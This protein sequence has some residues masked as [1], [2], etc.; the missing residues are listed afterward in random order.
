[1]LICESTMDLKHF[2]LLALVSLVRSGDP[3]LQELK[4]CFTVE[5]VISFMQLFVDQPNLSDEH[6]N[7]FCSSLGT[8]RACLKEK[9]AG[10]CA[11]KRYKRLMDGLIYLYPLECSIGRENFSA[12][13]ECVDGSSV[14]IAC[15]PEGS[16]L[17]LMDVDPP[18]Y[19]GTMTERLNCITAAIETDCGGRPAADSMRQYYLTILWLKYG[20][21]MRCEEFSEVFGEGEVKDEV[22]LPAPSTPSADALSS[23]R[24]EN[25]NEDEA[26]VPV[27]STSSAG[28]SSLVTSKNRSEVNKAVSVHPTSS[29]EASSS[30]RSDKKTQVPMTKAHGVEKGERNNYA[31]VKSVMAAALTAGAASATKLSLIAAAVCTLISLLL[32]FYPK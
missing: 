1:V 8:R 16:I 23:V 18:L 13:M 3:C 14:V 5:E 6:W 21:A 20:E 24:S 10:A 32:N 22:A 7:M 29:A 11:R 31:D 30:V 12:Y 26:V 19:C 9:Q 2:V 27:P 25:L 17:G 15:D 4:S 28:D